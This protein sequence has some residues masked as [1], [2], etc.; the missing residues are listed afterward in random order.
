MYN[1]QI[2]I[3]QIP[4]YQGYPFPPMQSVPPYYPKNMQWPPNM[5]KSS[6]QPNYRNRKSSS[7]GRKQ[8]KKEPENAEDRG[9]DSSDS[10]SGSD[11][12]SHLQQDRQHSSREH[13]KIK[14]HRKKS[15]RTVVIRNINY[16]SPKG[17]DGKKGS[18][19]DESTPDEEEFING[20]SLKKEVENA[21]GN[22]ATNQD[23][24]S[25]LVANASEGG[26]TKNWN[27]F[28]K[29]LM[30]DDETDI[31]EVDKL[32]SIDVQDEHFRLRS[33]EGGNSFPAG[34]AV[35]MEFEK[36]PKRLMA[37]ADSF[38]V[39]ERKGGN[40][41]SAEL[42][43]FENGEN[44]HPVMKR[45][46]SADEELLFSQRI[47]ESGTDSQNTLSTCA[48]ESTK[49]KTGRMED[50]FTVNHSGMSENH[51]L[52]INQTVLGGDCILSLEGDCSH[53]E[54]SRIGTLIDDSFMIETRPTVDDQYDS[55]W[56]TDISMET[57][58]ALAAYSENGTSDI[59]HVKHEKSNAN[60]PDDLC[61]VFERDSRL[62][63]AEVSWTMDYGTDISFTEANR[64]CSV[65]ETSDH[66]DKK[67][68]S[69]CKSS[70]FNNEATEIKNPSK[71]A[72][73]K[74]LRGSLGKS[75][76]EVLSKSKK[77]ASV[78]RPIVQKSKL[79]KVVTNIPFYPDFFFAYL[80]SYIFF[81]VLNNEICL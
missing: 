73:S 18:V 51:D 15:S 1:F 56:K 4:P 3:Q 62:E 32:R 2:P 47:E 70:D 6:Q 45:R 22:D 55:Q 75:K 25:D 58:I 72:R 67:L 11:S 16:I 64:R 34:P 40:D 31:R 26:K 54:K 21:V 39:T 60:E 77:P 49:I 10:D 50:W 59:S 74:V 29:L 19:S 7:A 80:P 13:Q 23:L 17:R 38:I 71:E 44:F 48:A 30:K 43:D 12:D 78:S 76:T 33:S 36:A 42:E 52:N 46:D 8:N 5:D 65:V 35:E 28:Q 57:D 61:V 9:T 68:P 79:E 37:A 41:G 63:S 53:T 24:N 20:D 66:V 14:K 69:N 81:S 27:A